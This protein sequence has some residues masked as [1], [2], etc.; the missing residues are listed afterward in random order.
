[1][2]PAA[3]LRYRA[4]PARFRRAAPA[5]IRRESVPTAAAR[6]RYGPPRVPPPRRS[7]DPPRASARISAAVCRTAVSTW[8]SEEMPLL[9]NANARRSRSFDSGTTRMPRIPTTTRSPFSQIA[10]AAATCAFSVAHH[11]HRVHALILHFDPLAFMPHQ[12]AMIGG[13]IKILGRAAIALHGGELGVAR[14]H[15]RAT[16]PQQT[17]PAAAACPTPPAFPLSGADTKARRWC[18]RCGTAPLRTGR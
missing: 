2:F 3:T 8:R 4:R 12:R 9:M 10:Q 11:D 14:I 13:R 6:R 15:G 5:P 16:Q 17:A 18:A 1:M 7:S